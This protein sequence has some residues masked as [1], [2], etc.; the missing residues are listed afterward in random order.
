M[1]L[2]LSDS[3]MSERLSRST[4]SIGA[5]DGI[6]SPARGRGALIVLH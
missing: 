1:A 2:A 6:P 4:P 3:D 5:M